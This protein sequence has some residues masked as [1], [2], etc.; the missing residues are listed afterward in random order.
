MKI[1]CVSAFQIEAYGTKFGKPLEKVIIANC[2]ISPLKRRHSKRQSN[3][4]IERPTAQ[5]KY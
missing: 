3:Q 1:H 4:S 2:G 5:A